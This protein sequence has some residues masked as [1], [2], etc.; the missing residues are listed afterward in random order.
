[1]LDSLRGPGLQRTNSCPELAALAGGSEGQEAE[2]DVPSGGN[3]SSSSSGGGGG[4]GP[5]APALQ[6]KSMA[7]G[8]LLYIKQR[9]L[10]GEERG[11]PLADPLPTLRRCSSAG[12]L[13]PAGAAAAAA[14]AA[15]AA[16]YRPSRR[17]HFSPQ[18]LV[19]GGGG[20]R[21]H[22]GAAAAVLAGSARGPA[23]L[24]AGPAG[25]AAPGHGAAHPLSPIEAASAPMAGPAP[26][27]APL[28]FPT[29]EAIPSCS[30]GEQ[31][32]LRS[33]SAFDSLRGGTAY[34]SAHGGCAAESL[35]GGGAPGSSMDGAAGSGAGAEEGQLGGLARKASTRGPLSVGDW[36]GHRGQQ[37]LAAASGGGGAP[38]GKPRKKVSFGIRSKLKKLAFGEGEGSGMH[39][40]LW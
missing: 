37:A 39:Q 9:M 32:S 36:S 5:G 24:P 1:M 12:E 8:Q 4:A 19:L 29:L 18:P 22:G 7:V 2:G 23:P 21:V 27:P 16:L 10:E 31:S 35:R 13:R 34:G 15:A 20:S 26:V 17:P 30:E 25:A 40:P 11:P 3:S 33:G 28:F 38:A 6:R 14:E